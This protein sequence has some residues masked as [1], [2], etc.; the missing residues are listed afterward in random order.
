MHEKDMNCFFNSGKI[1]ESINNRNSSWQP[2][3][4]KC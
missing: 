3:G 2:G 4:T 1:L